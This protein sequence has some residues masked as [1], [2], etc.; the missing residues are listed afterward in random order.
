VRR[1]RFLLPALLAIA[2]LAGP[3]TGRPRPPEPLICDFERDVPGQW[4]EGWFVPPAVASAGTT[5][6]VSADEPATGERCVELVKQGN[7][8]F[9]N[10]MQS[11]DARP[12]RGYRVRFSASVRVEPDAPQGRAQLWMRV[13]RA[14][15]RMGFFDNMSDR[16]IRSD[17]WSAYEIV[18]DVA[19]DA[20]SINIGLMM[21]GAGRAWLDDVT[22]EAVGE[23]GTGAE[24]ARPL[25]DRGMVN[26]CAFARLLGYVRHFHPSDQAAATDW[27]LLAIKGVHVVE[28]AADARDL[29]ERL[30]VLFAPVA[31][32]VMIAAARPEAVG[33]PPRRGADR[34]TY[35]V[36]YGYGQA[37]NAPPQSIYRSWRVKQSIA[38]N[39]ASNEVVPRPGDAVERDLGGG[40][41]CRVPL[42][43]YLDRTGTVPRV[44]LPD[45]SGNDRFDWTPPAGW[46][47]DGD[48]RATRLAAVILAWNVFQHFYPYFD[49][50]DTDWE[51]VLP[52]ALGRAAEDPDGAAFADTL[53][54][55]VHALHDGHGRVGG[56][57]VGLPTFRLPFELAWIEGHLVVT[58]ARVVNGVGA[59]P[60]DVVVSIDGKSAE[61]LWEEL[62]PLISAATEQW[63]RYRALGL[64]VARQGPDRYTA[65]LR[66]PDG[67]Q[68]SI[69]SVAI[70][71]AGAGFGEPRPGKIAE[72]ERGI[73]YVD[74]DRI[75][76]ED[77]TAALPDLAGADGIVFDLRGY[78]SRLSTIVIAHLIDEPVTC[79]Q[80]HVPVV[81][82]PDR[83][84][85]EFKFS[86][87]QVD[88]QAPRL[89]A[90]AAF[91]TDGRAISYAET[92]LGIVE[93]YHLAEIVGGPTA[94][95]NGNVNPLT[96][97]G[98]YTITW[99]GMKVLKH[100]GSQHH[101]VGIQPRVP[102]ERTIRGVAEGRD[103]LLE[104]AVEVVK[105]GEH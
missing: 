32:T 56:R 80:W 86:D 8:S 11:I 82:R 5:A 91:I 69:Q 104:K 4:A 44:N 21:I 33:P 41:W 20:Q 63:A 83:E 65:E 46:T 76:D 22:L 9:G 12:Y 95:T 6:R 57:A 87:W 71:A 98:G 50:V 1:S 55:M 66:K 23:A 7:L 100:D 17:R 89:T 24:P 67:R 42:C 34:V 96:L 14:G 60:G 10:L 58:A 75:T 48:D 47:P 84:K 59:A 27:E 54:R 25:T 70:P 79:A 43:L 81:R 85:M 19:P 72:I 90:R 45:A 73:W 97:P 78:P 102:V 13:D 101:G 52:E 62:E 94:G 53:R 88:P 37:T 26:L 77:F 36:H 28:G 30:L 16:P 61:Q 49:V 74:L 15:G 103:E 68:Y 40:V 99:T 29:S 92:Y 64:I 38:E 39:D 35:W 93:Q 3:A 105:A 18:G 51:A 31:P 2:A